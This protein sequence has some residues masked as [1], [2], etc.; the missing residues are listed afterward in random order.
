[1]VWYR[2]RFEGGGKPPLLL[3]DYAKFGARFEVDQRAIFADT[4]KYL[5]AAIEA[6]NERA[7]TP[8]ELARRHSLNTAL[9]RRWI[10][11]LGLEA[12]NREQ[13]RPVP[14]VALE[15]LDTPLPKREGRP[16]INGWGPRGADLPVLVANASKQIENIPGRVSPHGIAVHPTPTQFVAAVWKSPLEGKVRIH[17]KVAHA[18][19]ACGNGVAW[20]LEHRRANKA[21]RLA[22]GAVDL[23]KE[24]KVRSRELKVA[25]GDLI[26]LAVDPRDANHVCDLTEISFTITETDKPGRVWD[27]ASD[28]SDNVLAGNPHADKRGN[29]DVWRFVRGP[30]RPIRQARIPSGSLLDRWRRIAFDPKQKTERDKLARQVR[31]LLIGARPARE[32]HPDRLLYDTL[33]S[34]DG[35]VLGGMDWTRLPKNPSAG[36]SRYGLDRGRFGRHPQGKSADEVSLI[37]PATSVVEVRLPAPLFQERA[38]VV[39]GRLDPDG[40]DRVVQFQVLTAPPRADAPL[41]GKTP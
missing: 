27:L 5:D 36:P 17:A 31:A 24:T 21:S 28:V 19:P 32:K 2:P 34:L 16:A 13:G 37:A 6:V 29:A 11:V 25:K 38:F 20:W 40:P 39:E 9:L 26:T 35:P 23:G 8:D 18:H 33:L 4:V 30:V 15:L 7:R 10:D 22:E 12:S 3:R 14:A 1:I 41:D